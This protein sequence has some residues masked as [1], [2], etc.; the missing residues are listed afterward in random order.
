MPV[1]E[2]SSPA[3]PLGRDEPR[4]VAWIHIGDTHLTHAGEPNE[5]DLG[6]IVDEVN[7]VFARHLDFVYVPGDIADAGNAA[8][9]ETFRSH[10]DRLTVPW[11][12][13][14]GD[15]DVHA[16][17]FSN[18]QRYVSPDLTG[19]FTAG[20][21]RFLRLNAFSVPRPDSFAVDEAQLAWLEREL[22][23]CEREG[24]AAVLLLHCYPSDLKQGGE[25]LRDLL[26][27]YPVLLV[28]MGHTHYNEVS[29]DG[30]VLYS[31]T[32]S[33][34]QIEEGEVGYSLT[35]LDEGVV[36]WHFIPLGSASRVVITTPGDMRLTTQRTGAPAASGTLP[37][38]ARVWSGSRIVSA[39]A[40]LGDQRFPLHSAD[41]HLWAGALEL[42]PHTGNPCDLRVVARDEHGVELEDAIRF[43]PGGPP[44]RSVE[45]VD[46]GNAI[47]EWAER[48]L[49]GT[50]LGPNKN[51]RKW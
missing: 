14:V 28:D 45:P 20:T 8:A 12:G 25:A 40:R 32:R 49:L 2:S 33:T 50:Q 7:A 42:P 26:R 21:Y 11:I 31:A 37:V 27:R 13:I 48:G 4:G 1:P 46:Q 10:M 6:R 35:T 5:I 3:S 24:R 16:R 34:G 44:P 18:F 47:G 39:E 43:V 41:G 38:R 22:S 51:G 29:N 9:Y 36:S 19:S 30:A 17:S 23:L 15:H